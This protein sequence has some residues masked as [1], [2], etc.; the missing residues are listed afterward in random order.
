MPQSIAIVQTS[1]VSSAELKALCAE[2]MPEVTVQEIID[3]SLIREVNAN[4]GPTGTHK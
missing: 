4:G 1:A 3:S 2:I